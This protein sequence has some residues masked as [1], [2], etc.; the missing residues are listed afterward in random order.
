VAADTTE[1]NGGVAVKNKFS[2]CWLWVVASL[3]A[4]TTGCGT[5]TGTQVQAD[6]G[7]AAAEGLSL[8][9]LEVPEGFALI[10]D[11]RLGG[12]PVVGPPIHVFTG[13]DGQALTM[14]EVHEVDNRPAAQSGELDDSMTGVMSEASPEK[15]GTSSAIHGD[16][17]GR[18][19]LMSSEFSS[20]VDLDRMSA[21][22]NTSGQVP[23]IRGWSFRGSVSPETQWTLGLAVDADPIAGTVR[24]SWSTAA[25]GDD[26]AVSKW[27]TISSVPDNP[28]LIIAAL[29]ERMA[30]EPRRICFDSE[31]T[32]GVGLGEFNDGLGVVLNWSG[33][34]PAEI[35]S[36]LNQ[37]GA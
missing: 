36:L 24:S 18:Q 22:V 35:E 30:E 28:E 27:I 34:T 29:S 32:V 20:E 26:L 9:D 21:L 25:P 7:S 17:S 15:S 23:D 5:P 4:L 3:F 11:E 31:C 33:L 12:D 13:P 8:T 19:W 6:K 1:T 14:S 16:A 37:I 10:E 2:W